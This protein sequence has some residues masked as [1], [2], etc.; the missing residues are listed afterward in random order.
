MDCFAS[1]A[2]VKMQLRLLPFLRSRVEF[3]GRQWS[4][5]RGIECLE[6]EKAMK[7]G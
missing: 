4:H 3:C 2:C 1:E 5:D 7:R 6:V